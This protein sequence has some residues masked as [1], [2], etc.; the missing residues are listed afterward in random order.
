MIM[1][2]ELIAFVQLAFVA[3]I[4]LFPV[5]NPIGTAF[6]VAPYFAR[7]SSTERRAA[8]RRIAIY[9]LSVCLIVLLA[10]HWILGIFG[11][12]VPVVQLAGGIMI[13][14]LGWQHLSE[15]SGMAAP[16]GGHEGQ[17]IDS[18]PS[19]QR[20]LFYPLTFPLTTGAGTISVLFTL[21]A[22]GA[23]SVRDKA[24]LI[25]YL[26]NMAAIFV[27]IV[28][29]C[30]IVYVLY[31]NAGSFVRRLGPERAKIFDR[32]MAFLIFCV[33]LQIA[34]N[35]AKALGLVGH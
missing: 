3:F 27:A 7:L 12:S 13:S 18:Y 33:G 29:M 34:V 19:V 31:A 8:S 28:I 22:E 4:A 15:E 32:M 25:G 23:G 6:I 20:Q 30:S 5:V 26:I 10:G 14:K 1:T 17:Q 24:L 11:L 16:Q 35:G 9:A 2:T 21:S